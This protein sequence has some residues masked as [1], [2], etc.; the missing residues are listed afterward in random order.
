M[1]DRNWKSIYFEINLFSKVLSLKSLMIVWLSLNLLKFYVYGIKA[2][3]V[4]WNIKH[5]S[6]WDQVK[7]FWE[8]SLSHYW[9]WMILAALLDDLF[10]PYLF[11]KELSLR[12]DQSEE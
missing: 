4:S 9:Y 12:F 6:S 1:D 7:A 3:G 5:P 8:L 10:W 2:W 11:R